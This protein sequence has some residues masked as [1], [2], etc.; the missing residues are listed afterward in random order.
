MT[1]RVFKCTSDKIVISDMIYVDEFHSHKF[2]E[3]TILFVMFLKTPF[4]RLYFLK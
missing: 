3:L 1:K 4:K 2:S